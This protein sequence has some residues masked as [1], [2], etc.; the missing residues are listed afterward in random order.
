MLFNDIEEIEQA[1]EEDAKAA[2]DCLSD[3]AWNC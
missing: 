3:F 1:V 2:D